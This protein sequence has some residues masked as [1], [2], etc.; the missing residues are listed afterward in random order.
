[1]TAFSNLTLSFTSFKG[2]A[3]GGIKS[4]GLA[5]KTALGPIG[6]ALLAIEGFVEAYNWLEN[7][8]RQKA[9]EE[10]KET[11]RKY[12][13]Q[14]VASSNGRK[15]REQVVSEAVTYQEGLKARAKNLQ[16]IAAKGG[17]EGKAASK[18]LEGVLMNI[19]QR[20]SFV[21]ALKDVYKEK[22][23]MEFEVKSGAVT[24]PSLQGSSELSKQIA[25]MTKA[26]NESSN[27]TKKN[28]KATEANTAAQNK[29][30]I[31]DLSRQAFDAAFNVKLRELTLGTI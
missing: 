16:A 14:S 30:N 2:I 21:N 9:T 29:F 12:I 7:R 24:T 11:A 31:S 20:E 8:S 5:M 3:V 23:G 1:M 13:A 15:T 19:R 6:I 26:L 27:S 28:T 10:Q 25:E 4:I 22:T 17:E 18:E